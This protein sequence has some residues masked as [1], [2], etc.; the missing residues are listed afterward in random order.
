MNRKI[1]F[2]IWDKLALK[3]LNGNYT[4]V[5]SNNIYE[6]IPA[7]DFIIQQFTG[8]TDKNGI[9][10]YEGDILFFYGD[11]PSLVNRECTVKWVEYLG[12]QL[13]FSGGSNSILSPSSNI[14]VIGNIFQRKHP[15]K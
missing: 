6:L 11:Y 14:E 8:L 12:F 10:I 3:W 5:E 7:T 13:S 4:L 9:E 1:K 15:Q 2:R